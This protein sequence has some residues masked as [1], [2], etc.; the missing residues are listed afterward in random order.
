MSDIQTKFSIGDRVFWASM[1]QTR[2]RHPCPDC[3]D[4]RVWAA[5]SPAGGAYSMPC[6][7]CSA[8]YSGF[9]DL[10]L[11]YTA[12]EGH[13]VPL[14]VGSIRIDTADEN[15]VSYM[16]R[17]TGVGCGSIY[18]ETDM[19]RTVEEAEAAAAAKAAV[20][21]TT[22][23]WVVKLYNRTLAVSD[24]QLDNAALSAARDSLS[25]TRVDVSMLFDDLR[26]CETMDEVRARL[27]KGFKPRSEEPVE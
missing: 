8:S 16:C 22:A 21:N 19:F 2:K 25:A 15:P 24:Y 23:E 10:R 18:Y 13:T 26:D 20:A 27:D 12:Y 9:D 17:E 1:I 11:D 14:T 3:L 4:T 5:Q 7:R 6:P